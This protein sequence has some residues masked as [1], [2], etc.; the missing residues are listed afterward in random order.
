MS[1]RLVK[2]SEGVICSA[3]AFWTRKMQPCPSSCTR[4]FIWNPIWITDST[5]EDTF[6]ESS[7]SQFPSKSIQTQSLV[8]WCKD[9]HLNHRISRT[10]RTMLHDYAS[11]MDA[12]PWHIPCVL[13]SF[14]AYAAAL[15]KKPPH[16]WASQ[17]VFGCDPSHPHLFRLS[18]VSSQSSLNSQLAV[19]PS[20]LRGQGPQL[21]RAGHWF[22][23]LKHTA[24]NKACTHVHL[25]A[26]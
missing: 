13:D 9:K 22:G 3:P 19:V 2:L 14:C 16:S 15:V 7:S 23:H 5:R 21:I 10:K 12:P 25:P 6:T 26:L 17:S 4:V 18:C 1:S 11:H 20:H 24:L 8:T